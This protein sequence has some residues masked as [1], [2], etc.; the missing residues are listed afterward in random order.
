ML[1]FSVKSSVPEKEHS[2]CL[3]VGIFESRK[4][5]KAAESIDRASDGFIST[6]VRRGDMDGELGDSLLLHAVPGIQAERVLLVGLGKE[7]EF[8]IKALRK[9]MA[10]SVKALDHRGTSEC[11][12]Y[13]T[14]L[15]VRGT[16]LNDTLKHS[17]IAIEDAL[18]RFDELKTDKDDA[19][20]QPLRRMVFSIPTHHALLDA[21]SA[22]REGMAIASG[23]QLT[24]DLANR[25]GNICTPS[26]LAEQARKLNDTY[27]ALM[28]EVLDESHMSQLGMGALLAVAKGSREAPKFIIMK[29]TG[30][31]ADTPP[32]VLVGKGVTFDSGGIS[33][34]PGAGM[35]EMKFDM[36]GAA[37][38]IGIMAVCAELRLPLNVVALIPS[39]ENMA[40]GNALKPGDIV[41]SMSGQTIEVLNTDAEGR[42]ILCDALTYAERY[43]P[44]VVIDMATLTGACVIALGR[45]PSGLFANHQD[46]AQELI[47]AGEAAMDR[48]WQMPLWDEYQDLLKSNFADMANIGGREGGAIT[49]ACFLSRF[50]K[51]YRWAHLDIAGTAWVTGD[52]KGATGRPVPLM[53]EFL[54][55]RAQKARN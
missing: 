53:S 47:E 29:H 11:V 10:A 5:T 43:K 24:R 55:R 39:V 18:Y 42:L 27:P 15:D 2:A 9:A 7:Q 17:V 25:P 20:R 48:V 34:K 32:I 1:E 49:A 3:I 6:I 22:L 23:M 14:E 52:K 21:E 13:L 12:S 28:V 35:D 51:E 38:V 26:Y 40:D 4:L 50:T 45:E 8:D 54:I 31:D 37:A 46:L 30:L 41:T 16:E 19:P 33:L 44:E 36:S